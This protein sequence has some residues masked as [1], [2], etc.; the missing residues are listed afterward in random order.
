MSSLDIE[1]TR[2]QKAPRAWSLRTQKVSGCSVLPDHLFLA[3]TQTPRFSLQPP[4]FPPPCV[5]LLR[6][7]SPPKHALRS[8]PIPLLAV[9][10]FPWQTST[11]QPAPTLHS[12][13]Y[14]LLASPHL[15]LLTLRGNIDLASGRTWEG[16]HTLM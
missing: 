2:F 1:V 4:V 10:C 11:P 6:D 14:Q 5:F 7:L 15:R 3:A 8:L 16:P 9:L 13:V 12:P